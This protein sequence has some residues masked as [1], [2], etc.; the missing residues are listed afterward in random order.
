MRLFGTS[1][2][3]R[4]LST[5]LV[6]AIFARAAP[7]AAQVETALAAAE[8][9]LVAVQNTDG[10]FGTLQRMAPRD[11]ALAVLALAGGASPE[12]AVTQGAIYLQ[13]VPEA[14][15][16]FRSH[17]AL[18]LAKTGR[19]YEPLLVSLFDFRNGGGFGAFASH[20]SNLLDTALAVE[21]LSLREGGARSPS[22]WRS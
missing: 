1:S 9:Y 22:S 16:S 19:G 4:I 10:S 14:N 13:G 5:V 21:A 18:A 12:P 15:T 6:A 11:S 7:L 8:D 20:E 17:R 2:Q 3:R